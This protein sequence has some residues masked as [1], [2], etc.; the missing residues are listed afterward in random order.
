MVFF[1]LMSD[2]RY[3]RRSHAK[4]FGEHETVCFSANDVSDAPGEVEWTFYPYDHDFMSSTY[5]CS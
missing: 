4:H 3:G 5:S 1:K 2:S